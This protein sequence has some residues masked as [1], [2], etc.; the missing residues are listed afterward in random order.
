[1]VLEESEDALDF[2]RRGWRTGE[3]SYPGSLEQEVKDQAERT[4]NSPGA[5]G[6]RL[7]PVGDV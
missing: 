4:A 1:M 5:Q 3:G 6:Q 7:G 2:A